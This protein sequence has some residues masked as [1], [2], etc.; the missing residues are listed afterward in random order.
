MTAHWPRP[1]ENKLG[2]TDMIPE[3]VVIRFKKDAKNLPYVDDLD[4]KFEELGLTDLQA[5][6]REFPG[7]KMRRLFTS[8]DPNT[9]GRL[10]KKADSSNGG[11][12]GANLL[13]HYRLIVPSGTKTE[14]VVRKFRR[15][16]IIEEVYPESGP[17]PPPL[18]PSHNPR[19]PYETYLQPAHAGIDASYAWTIQGGDGSGVSFVDLEQGWT[20]DHQDLV[21][22]GVNVMSGENIAYFGHGTAVLGEV[23]AVDNSKGGI[24]IAPNVTSAD[25]ISQF[26][27]PS[28]FNTAD[29]ILSA[30][31]SMS[32]G[33][34]LLLEAQA[35]YNGLTF[36]PVEVE[37]AVFN[38]I[39]LATSLG[40]IVVEA[41]GNGR[42][43]LDSFVTNSGAQV[44]NRNSVDFRD[45]GAIMVGASASSVPHERWNFDATIGSSFGNRIDC[46][47]WGE[48]INTSGDPFL[49]PDIQ[50]F[51]Y[52][53]KMGGTSG[54]SAI[55]AGATLCVQ[56]ISKSLPVP[57]TLSPNQ[58]RTLLSNPSTS[59]PSADPSVDKIGVMPNLRA[60][61]T[62]EI[63]LSANSYL[64]P[65]PVMLL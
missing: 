3:T 28:D 15:V 44:L 8:V 45:S 35:N 34:V 39:S 49:P 17:L 13:Q 14:D 48:N 63:G 20:L 7:L 40:I 43:D 6:F 57:T 9:I 25:V 52:T 58:M 23:V 42:N 24:G 62:N 64:E 2:N 46:Y 30:A 53:D 54:A 60:I 59:T 11:N 47:S 26:R 27:S 16:P 18:D 38:A 37:T 32:S 61:I 56:G 19:Y 55:I 1:N 29:A 65:G 10:M 5:V 36:L 21:S 50:A 22:K 31:S 51:G 12:K 33:D 4:A 41:A